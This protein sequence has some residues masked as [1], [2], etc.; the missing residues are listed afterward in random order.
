M[1]TIYGK[2]TNAIVYTTNNEEYAIDDYARKQIQMI[3][4]HP[5]SVGSKIRIMP[6]VHPGKVGTI[7]LTMTIGDS[8]LP[9]LVGVDIGCGMTIA[10]IKA[11]NI[12]YQKL[13]TVIREHVP[14]GGKVRKTAH[15]F[16]HTI[17]LSKLH[18]YKAINEPKANLSIGTLGGGNHFIEVD[19]DADNAFYLVIHSGS[20]HL[21]ME[22]TEYYLKEGQKISQMKKQGHAPY[23]MTCLEGDL[24]QSYFHDL[25]I[26]QDF[27]RINREAM[28]DEIV[29]GMKWR[30]LDSYTCIHN[31]VDFSGELPILRKGAIR[32]NSDE[33]V[34]IPIN[35]RDGIILGTGLGNEDWNCSAPHG[36]GRIYKRSEVKEHHTVSE[37][38]A[39]MKGIHSICVNKDTLDESPFAYRKIE[40]IVD[41][42]GETII[43]DNIIKPTYN[44][45]AGGIN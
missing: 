44:F 36:S 17:D 20:R 43:I 15:K 27:A 7:G 25:A 38:K 8:L 23:E 21:G 42:I 39:A 2:Y 34:I 24:L 26:T 12:E 45:K 37:F 31:Y 10:K 4:N 41:V 11:K 16:S 14:S 18:C 9:S 6:D 29:R 33:K 40:D 1:I 32:A 5:S 19:K 3:C 30:I 35:M 28:I 22:V 13:D